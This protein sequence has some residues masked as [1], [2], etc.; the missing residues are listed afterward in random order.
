MNPS[1]VIEGVLL[2]AGEP[3]KLSE[4]ATAAGITKPEVAKAIE[5]YQE[6]SDRGLTIVTDGKTAQLVT[7]PQ[8]AP[9]VARFT[10]AE[11]RGNLSPSALETLAIIAYRGPVTRPEIE[12]VRGVSTSAPLRTLA[13]RGL[14][15]EAGRRQDPGRPILYETSLEL[16]KHLGIT[17]T[18]ELPKPPEQTEQKLAT[19]QETATA[20]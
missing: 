6:Q 11:L 19:A 1:A 4:L 20:G 14:I 5:A 16:L 3:V 9:Q 17:S 8:V 18:S 12:T 7:A 13:I 10:Q 15:R 2:A